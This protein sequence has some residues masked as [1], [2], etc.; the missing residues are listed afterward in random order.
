[1]SPQRYYVF[2]TYDRTNRKDDSMALLERGNIERDYTIVG[3]KYGEPENGKEGIVIKCSQEAEAMHL[4]GC[5][6]NYVEVV[7]VPATD[8]DIH[9]MFQV[10]GID[11]GRMG[12]D[13]LDD[14]DDV[15]ADYE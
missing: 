12:P 14:A 15:D 8:T 7:D 1:M 6:R 4:L 13:D 5:V 11:L 2:V 3:I 10:I 9:H